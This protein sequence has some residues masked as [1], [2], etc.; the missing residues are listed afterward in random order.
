[1]GP[2]GRQRFDLDAGPIR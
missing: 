2:V 1:M